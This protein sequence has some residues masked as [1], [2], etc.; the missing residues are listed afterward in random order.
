MAALFCGGVL[1]GYYLGSKALER[2]WINGV[3]GVVA[4][5][6]ILSFVFTTMVGW[7]QFLRYSAN[8]SLFLSSWFVLFFSSWCGLFAASLC[9]AWNEIRRPVSDKSF[10]SLR[11]KYI[12]VYDN[13][14]SVSGSLS[15]SA[16]SGEFTADGLDK[17]QNN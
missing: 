8:G 2:R 10:S 15:A 16:A 9:Q 1:L 7:C 12:I 17:P 6:V 13:P 4:L 3:T 14:K 5:F 11:D